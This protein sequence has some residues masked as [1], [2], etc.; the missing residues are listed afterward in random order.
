VRLTAVDFRD[1]RIVA[2]AAIEP[3]ALNLLVGPN[4]AGKTSLLEGIHLLGTG[5]SFTPVRADGLIRSAGGPLRVVGRLQADS[6]GQ[7]HRI[8][9][10]RGTTEGWRIRLDGAHVERIADLARALPV[11]AIHPASHEIL[12]GGPG[13]RR[14]LLDWGL[15]HVEPDY[16]R[17]WQRY[18]RAV[19][20]RNALLRQ[21][22]GRR[23][24]E[25]WEP[26]V[27]VAGERVDAARRRYVRYLGE[28]VASLAGSIMRTPPAVELRYRAGWS[29]QRSL[30][31]AL[32]ARRERDRDVQTTTVGPHR[33]DLAVMVD[34]R[35]SRNRVSRGQQKL[36]VYIVRLAQ[37]RRHADETG[38]GP[39]LLLDDLGAELDP[40]HRERVLRAAIA[41]G[42]QIFVTALERTAIPA[43]AGSPEKTF[44]VEQGVVTE[45]L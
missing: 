27:V 17:A 14:R 15:F 45:L 28:H 40:E 18:R 11:L 33:A 34:G 30:A 4:A 22:A 10:E 38:G 1:L 21:R 24:L 35:D 2:R 32:V 44:H 31:E 6:G 39:V 43:I 8:G 12:A 3:G 37:A 23:E 42:S 26:E 25:A 29:E 9:I 36:L 13:E 16:L 19:A 7:E 5:R 20:Q 41:T